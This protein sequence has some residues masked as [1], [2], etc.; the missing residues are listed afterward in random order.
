M[1]FHA[2]T[3]VAGDQGA[4]KVMV[5]ENGVALCDG[6]AIAGARCARYRRVAE[7]RTVVGEVHL[8]TA[9]D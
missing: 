7:E 2:P 4:L 3:E 1:E 8:S 5:G 6:A 9:H